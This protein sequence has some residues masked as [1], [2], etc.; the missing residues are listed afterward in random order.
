[1]DDVD[2]QNGCM[3]FL[4]KS[5]KVGQLKP[6][7]L[8]EPEDLFEYAKESGLH[9]KKPVVVRMKAGSCTFHNGLTFHY[10]F[11]NQTNKPRRAFVMIFMPDGTTYNGKQH[12]IT[13]ELDL[14]KDQPLLGGLF[15]LLSK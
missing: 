9:D 15:P 1:L 4:P 12:P 11:A 6:I 8:A 7:N 3:M 14:N 5:H 2:E 13:S 10:A